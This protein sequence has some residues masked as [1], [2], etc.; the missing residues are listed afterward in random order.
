MRNHRAL[1]TAPAPGITSPSSFLSGGGRRCPMNP[2]ALPYPRSRKRA[3]KWAWGSTSMCGWIP[4]QAAVL[5]SLSELLNPEQGVRA[6]DT[7]YGGGSNRDVAKLAA[8]RCASDVDLSLVLPCGGRL[9]V[10]SHHLPERSLRGPLPRRAPTPGGPDHGSA[11]YSKNPRRPR[12]RPP[13]SGA[14]S[15]WR[16]PEH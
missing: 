9:D 2:A 12:R 1:L 15:A 3:S 6:G 5:E 7:Q 10:R 4:L 13:P 11:D 16:C 8:P 14:R